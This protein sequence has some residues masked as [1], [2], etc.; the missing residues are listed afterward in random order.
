MAPAGTP[1]GVVV[2]I[3]AEIAD[4]TRDPQIVER[5]TALGVDPVGNGPAEFSAMVRADID[6]WARAVKLAGLQAGAE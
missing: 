4:A 6:R 1:K 3:D 5:L 2:R